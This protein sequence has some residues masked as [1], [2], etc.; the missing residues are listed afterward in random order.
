MRSIRHPSV[1]ALCVTVGLAACSCDFQRR[2]GPAAP[3]S[4]APSAAPASEPGGDAETRPSAATTRAAAG[5]TTHAATRP[6]AAGAGRDGAADE[7]L[8]PEDERVLAELTAAVNRV[9][10]ADVREKRREPNDREKMAQQFIL[11][12][13]VATNGLN[14]GRFE[15]S[16]QTAAKVKQA[17][18]ESFEKLRA[19]HKDSS[20]ELRR[21]LAT[22]ERLAR[23]TSTLLNFL[24]RPTTFP[25]TREAMRDLAERINRIPAVLNRAAELERDAPYHN[26]RFELLSEMEALRATARQAGKAGAAATEKLAAQE[27]LLSALDE[28]YRAQVRLDQLSAPST[29]PSR[30]APSATSSPS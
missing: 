17:L 26:K 27:R 20:P 3:S 14:D 19:E 9:V 18:D 2:T 5:G 10:P 7:P 13:S 16:Q 29:R 1:L 28:Q 25:S 8:D 23:E 21:E 15:Q 22:V 24:D 4:A 12:L 30:G 6:S 11:L